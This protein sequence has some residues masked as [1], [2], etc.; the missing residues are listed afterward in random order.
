MIRIPGSLWAT[1][2][3]KRFH[4]TPSVT[5]YTGVFKEKG[6]SKD[7]LSIAMIILKRKAMSRRMNKS[8]NNAFFYL[9]A[10][11]LAIH[12]KKSPPQWEG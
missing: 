1:I 4:F 6:V 7:I 12:R 8:I 9:V 3:K 11:E 10:Y 2:D 5:P